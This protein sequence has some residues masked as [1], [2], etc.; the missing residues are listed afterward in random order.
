MGLVDYGR[1]MSA[2]DV[3]GPMH[4]DQGTLLL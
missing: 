2:I 1:Q 3:G 4:L